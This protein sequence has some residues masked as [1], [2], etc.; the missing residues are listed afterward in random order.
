MPA[1]AWKIARVS[2]SSRH[3]GQRRATSTPSSHSNG[4]AGRGHRVGVVV[5]RLGGVRRREVEAAGHRQDLLARGGLHLAPRRLRLDRELDV[6]APVVRQARDPR[7]VLRRAAVVA[8]LEL[9]EAEDPRARRATPRA[10]RRRRC[11]CRRARR[12]SRRT[13]GRRLG[14]HARHDS[15]EA[16]AY[17]RPRGDSAR[18]TAP[19]DPAELGRRAARARRRP[20]ERRRRALG[21]PL[22]AGLGAPPP[23]RRSSTSTRTARTTGRP[24]WDLSL[25]AYFAER[26]YAYCP[27][28]RPRDRQLRRRRAR[29][30]HRRGDPGRPR[31]RRVAGRAAVV[32]RQR[33]DVGP[34]VR[35]VHLDP[36]R[37][38]A[39][40]APAGHRSRSRRRTTGTPTTST[41]SAAR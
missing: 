28:R 34:V 7:H 2:G 15:G 38:N 35:R 20:G 8:E 1:S 6:L 23:C 22:P 24:G 9:L 21:E 37:G 19:V 32:H 25:A 17:P 26:G 11:R 10:G 13:F 5:D 14:G 12:R 39:A 27:P 4:D 40:A 41:T 31:R 3:A 36:G 29:R 33:R 30:V 18:V 16:R